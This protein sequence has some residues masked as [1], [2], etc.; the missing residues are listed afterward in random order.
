[1]AK[2]KKINSTIVFLG[3]HNIYTV[4]Q[5]CGVPRGGISIG[6]K[7][8]I[9]ALKPVFHRPCYLYMRSNYTQS[10][11]GERERIKREAGSTYHRTI[12]TIK[13][14]G[15]AAF[16]PVCADLMISSIAPSVSGPTDNDS[17]K[18]TLGCLHDNGEKSLLIIS[19]DV[20]II[21]FE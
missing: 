13:G 5:G 15:L 21:H 18:V 3:R 11:S 1:M 17:S 9:G 8:E 2:I 20:V 7:R 6:E 16:V 10:L 14:I 4:T 19:L 12:N